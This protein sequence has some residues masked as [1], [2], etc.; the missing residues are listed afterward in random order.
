[1]SDSG[2]IFFNHG[3]RHCARLVVALLSLR[4]HYRGP[5]TILDTGHSDGIIE[6]IAADQRLAVEVERIPFKAL[7]RHSCYV[8]KSSLWRHSPYDVTL[9]L[10][11]DTLVARPIDG[12]LGIIADPKNPGWVVT[13]FSDWVTTGEIISSRIKQWVNVEC[14]GISVRRLL[15]LSLE[16]PLPAINTGVV[17]WR[18]DC[19]ALERWE[20][21]TRDGWKCSFTDELA[22]QLLLRQERHTLVADRYNC[23]PLYGRERDQAVIFH[24]HGSKHLIRADGRG[25]VANAIWAP[26]FREAFAGNVGGIRSWAPAGDDTL[27][28]NLGR[29]NPA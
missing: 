9:F 1:M 17:G 27:A 15:R 25:I 12:L 3:Q 7:R 6:R 24:A 18:A 10:D 16:S 21:L 4:R 14:E 13:R 26:L 29:F 5:A 8:M 20:R 23:S 19:E 28:H 11:A 22:A 2:V